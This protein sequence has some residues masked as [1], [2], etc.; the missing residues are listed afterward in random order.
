[1]LDVII[2]ESLITILVI[3]F[4]ISFWKSIDIP[5]K[6]FACLIILCL[7]ALI[8]LNSIKYSDP[9]LGKQPTIEDVV[10]G[11]ATVVSD[12]IIHK[13]VHWNDELK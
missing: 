13:T 1:M 12:T 9:H 2:F 4:T 3:I 5:E 7:F 6:T 11:K 8:T 10:N